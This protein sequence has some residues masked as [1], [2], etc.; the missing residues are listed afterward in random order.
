MLIDDDTLLRPDP[1]LSMVAAI[2]GGSAAAKRLSKGVYEIGHFGSSRWPDGFDDSPQFGDTKFWCYGVCDNV[3][4]ILAA[5]P[6]IG[7][8]EQRQFVITL[9]PV[10]RARQPSEGGWRWHKW[11][12]YIGA[13]EPQHEYLHD[14]KGIDQVLVYHVYERQSASRASRAA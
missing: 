3:D 13:H 2:N 8:S 6:E 14:E 9:T 1:I 4:Q 12:D 5:C 7:A 11:G 10:V